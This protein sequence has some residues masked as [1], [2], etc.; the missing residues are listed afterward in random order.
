MP[1]CMVPSMPNEAEVQLI[2][3]ILSDWENVIGS[4]FEGYKNHVIRMASF[5][6]A[7]RNCNEEEKMKTRI[8]VRSATFTEWLK[9]QMR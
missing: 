3:K 2:H 8:Q 6:F 7:I 9:G 5:C 4:A 1:H